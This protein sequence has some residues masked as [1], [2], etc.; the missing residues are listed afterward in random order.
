MIVILSNVGKKQ[1][2]LINKF[3]SYE[4]LLKTCY[5]MWGEN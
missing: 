3:V 5:I 1:F 4:P 2:A